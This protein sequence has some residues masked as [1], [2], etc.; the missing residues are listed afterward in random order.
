MRSASRASYTYYLGSLMYLLSPSGGKHDNM[1]LGSS[2][3]VPIQLQDIPYVVGVVTVVIASVRASNIG[4]SLW[5]YRQSH[6]KRFE[7]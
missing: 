4:N 2:S 1:R 5:A 6:S 3:S 7:E